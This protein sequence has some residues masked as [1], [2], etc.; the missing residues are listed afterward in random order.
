MT[1]GLLHISVKWPLEYTAN[2]IWCHLLFGVTQYFIFFIVND[3]ILPS[4]DVSVL[5]IMSNQPILFLVIENE[6]RNR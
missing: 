5:Y 1:S 4:K 3:N 6:I 2:D